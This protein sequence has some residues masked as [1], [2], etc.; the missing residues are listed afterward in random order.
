MG[1]YFS[2]VFDDDGEEVET[3]HSVLLFR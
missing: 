2:L 1:N 3:N